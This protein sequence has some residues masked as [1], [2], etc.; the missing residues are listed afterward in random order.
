MQRSGPERKTPE[1]LME[2][3]RAIVASSAA[4]NIQLMMRVGAL[5]TRSAHTVTAASTQAPDPAVAFAHGVDVLLRSAAIINSH[6]SAMM[7]E[8]LA[9]AEQALVAP[10]SAGTSPRDGMPDRPVELRLVGRVSERV[11]GQ[12]AVDNEY[13]SP[14]QVSFSAGSL[15]SSRG[16]TPSSGRVALDPTRTVIAAHGAAIVSVAVDITDDFTAGETY[17]STI[18]VVGFQTPD[19]RLQVVVSEEAAPSVSSAAVSKATLRRK[20]TRRT[21]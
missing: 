15:V 20:R 17:S 14:L 11:T 12:F 18:S 13:D 4:G 5:L 1:V 9:I 16:V 19:V 2:E 10:A 8:L 7:N 21:E 3:L 6:T